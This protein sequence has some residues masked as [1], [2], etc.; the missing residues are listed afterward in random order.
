MKII[1]LAAHNALLKYDNVIYQ[2]ING[3]RDIDG[4]MLNVDLNNFDILVATP[5]CNYYSRANYRRE[6]SEYS[7]K[8]KHLL[9]DIIKKFIKTGKPFVVENVINKKL[10][11][12]IIKSLPLN[13]Y[14][15]EYGRHS[16]FTNITPYIYGVPQTIENIQMISSNNRQGG[17][18]VNLV[19]EY[20]IDTE[21]KKRKEYRK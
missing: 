2:D 16:Y 6:V 9:P 8:T 11:K 18:N 13:V 21:L 10:M 12:D 17:N 5:P 1:Y 7:Q 4:C 15:I 3:L 14:Y 20:L 19:I